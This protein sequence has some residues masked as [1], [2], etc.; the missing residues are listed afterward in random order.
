MRFEVVALLYKCKTEFDHPAYKSLAYTCPYKA[1]DEDAFNRLKEMCN[2]K[3][4]DITK[5]KL[6]KEPLFNYDYQSKPLGSHTMYWV[7]E[8]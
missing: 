4:R 2:A 1:K 3:G 6:F 8:V 7:E 5:M